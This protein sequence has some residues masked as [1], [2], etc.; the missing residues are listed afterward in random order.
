MAVVMHADNM[1]HVCLS[2]SYSRV[3]LKNFF[4]VL[5][6]TTVHKWEIELYQDMVLRGNMVERG[7]AAASSGGIQDSDVG[8][9]GEG[10]ERKR[11]GRKRQA[12]VWEEEESEGGER[13]PSSKRRKAGELKASI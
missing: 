9:S 8:A 7:T 12:A 1:V 11:E 4:R 10:R 2:I 5:W 3:S 13:L 6:Q